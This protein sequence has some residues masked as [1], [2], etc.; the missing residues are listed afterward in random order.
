MTSSA[1]ATGS[2]DGTSVLLVEDEFL[3]LLDLEY[4]LTSAGASVTTATSLAEA[5]AAADGSYD[6]AV[7]DVRLPDGE[8]YPAARLLVDRDVPVVFHSGHAHNDNIAETFPTAV[9]LEKPA[10]ERTLIAAVERQAMQGAGR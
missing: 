3:I 4:V 10:L 7:L 5:M 1:D 2:L 8:V 9:A 6:V